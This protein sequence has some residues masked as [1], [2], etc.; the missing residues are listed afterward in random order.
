MSEELKN[1]DKVLVSDRSLARARTGGVQQWYIGKSREGRHICEC[2]AGEG[3]IN[4]WNYAVKVPEKTLVEWDSST[5]PHLPFVV[6]NKAFKVALAVTSYDYKANK[7]L[8]GLDWM[9][10]IT[11]LKNYNYMPDQSKPD[12]LSPCGVEVE[13]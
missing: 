2:S 13:A 6:V 3:T 7:F 12:E 1:G 9:Q 11:L 8:V 4:R 5:M 10:P